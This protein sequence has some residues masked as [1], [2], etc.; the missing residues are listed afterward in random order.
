MSLRPRDIAPGAIPLLL[1]AVAGLAWLA[2]SGRVPLT[3]DEAWN[4]L[5]LSRSGP[6]YALTHYPAPNNHVLFTVLQAVFLPEA[7]VVGSPLTLRLVNVVVL[8]S[9][10]L[11]LWRLLRTRASFHSFHAAA[12]SIA[13]LV[14]SPL[15]AT[16]C[17]VARGYLLGTLLLLLACVASVEEGHAARSGLLA[18]LSAM[19]VPTFAWAVP[20]LLLWQLLG[21]RHHPGWWERL[22]RP[23]ITF[24]WFAIPTIVFYARFAS[25]LR[26]FGKATAWPT[27]TVQV[28]LRSLLAELGNGN[29]LAGAVVCGVVLAMI[30][31][32]LRRP[33]ETPATAGA[34]GLAGAL[35]CAVASFL[36]NSLVN[37]LV[38][39]S[40]PTPQRNA[41]FLPLFLW[42]A[43]LVVAPA[44]PWMRRTAAALVFLFASLT[45]ARMTT[46]FLVTTPLEFPLFTDLSPTPI[47]RAHLQGRRDLQLIVYE[48]NAYAVAL[49]Y[50]EVLGVPTKSARIVQRACSTG[51]FP[52]AENARVAV[53]VQD[54]FEV[55]CY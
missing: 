9:L 16:Y 21:S 53:V 52:A 47:E 28:Y 39:G 15:I 13:L 37:P 30:V 2:L 6:L 26:H 48:E 7:L 45:L 50:G 19:V 4:F 1:A 23:L 31:A 24:A 33:T 14:C 55:L 27:Y 41:L 40:G 36:V 25:A 54:T 46:A 11:V 34:P 18:A 35:L 17:L 49:L 38:S 51:S 44:R 5:F 10:S 43:W 29:A 42:L 32:G 20:G 12:L 3:Y 8:L 22:R